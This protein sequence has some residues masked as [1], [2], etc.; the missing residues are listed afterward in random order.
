MSEAEVLT[1][2][3]APR[4]SAPAPKFEKIFE[5]RAPFDLSDELRAKVDA[6]GVAETIEEL[7]GN[8]YGY[9][10]QAGSPEFNARLRETIIRIAHEN[11]PEER[12]SLGGGANYLTGR[13]RSDRRTPYVQ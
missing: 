9:V 6:N 13:D 12:R 7:E 8:G 1:E 11:T 2:E 4:E 5:T 10:R 3:D